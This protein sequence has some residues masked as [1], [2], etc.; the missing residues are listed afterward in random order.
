MS[1]H[2]GNPSCSY[3]LYIHPCWQPFPLLSTV[4]SFYQ[5]VRLTFVSILAPPYAH[6]FPYWQPHLLIFI[7]RLATCLVHS[8]FVSRMAFYPSCLGYFSEEKETASI[9][10]NSRV[11]SGHGVSD[12][13]ETHLWTFRTNL[14]VAATV[15]TRTNYRIVQ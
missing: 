10:Y 4:Y 8:V 14:H 11:S 1:I 3:V 5:S 13:D 12:A 9:D 6:S 7:S 15:Y 2:S